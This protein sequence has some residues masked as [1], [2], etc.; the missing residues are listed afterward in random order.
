MFIDCAPLRC[1]CTVD[2]YTEIQESES[3]FEGE[4]EYNDD[5]IMEQQS[6][7]VYSR[8]RSLIPALPIRSTSE[9]QETKSSF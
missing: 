2:H 9:S 8:I 4:E 7:S 5:D 6:S 1:G 3:E